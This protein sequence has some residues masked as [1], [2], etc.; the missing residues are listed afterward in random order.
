MTC[1]RP[2]NTEEHKEETIAFVLPIKNNDVGENHT[3]API[4]P[5]PID[6]KCLLLNR[7]M[8]EQYNQNTKTPESICLNPLV[9]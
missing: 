1:V 8:K 6:M 7:K 4:L 9:F 3:S 2:I 5:A